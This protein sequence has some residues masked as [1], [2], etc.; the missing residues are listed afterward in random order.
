[1]T[2][3][4]GKIIEQMNYEKAQSDIKLDIQHFANGSYFVVLILDNGMK[5]NLPLQKR[6]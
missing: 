1:V 2:D 6:L 3:I 4:S 5:V